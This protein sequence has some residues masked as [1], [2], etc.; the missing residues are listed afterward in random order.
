MTSSIVASGADFEE[1]HLLSYLSLR[2]F[3]S[4]LYSMKPCEIKGKE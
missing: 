1:T 4:Q 3:S 2:G